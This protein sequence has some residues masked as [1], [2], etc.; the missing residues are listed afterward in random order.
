LHAS[1]WLLR[2]AVRSGQSVA[3]ACL[4]DAEEAADY[5]EQSAA[6]DYEPTFPYPKHAHDD[7]EGDQEQ[8]TGEND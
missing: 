7:A 1:G 8:R 3:S 5:D 2:G 4:H 6:G